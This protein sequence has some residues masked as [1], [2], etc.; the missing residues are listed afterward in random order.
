MEAQRLPAIDMVRT[1][2]NIKLLRESKHISVRELQSIFSFSTPQ[3]I[4]KWQN[5]TCLPTLDNIA[6]LA[7]VFDVS[8]E[9]ILVFLD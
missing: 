1:G 7:F 9:D 2:E 3:A 6:A 4:Y 8:I 5:G